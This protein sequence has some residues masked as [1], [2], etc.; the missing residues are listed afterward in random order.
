MNNITFFNNAGLP[1][2]KIS[3]LIKEEGIELKDWSPHLRQSKVKELYNV[4]YE[5]FTWEDKKEIVLCIYCLVHYVKGKSKTMIDT[6][7]IAPLFRKG[8]VINYNHRYNH[9]KN[10]ILENRSIAIGYTFERLNNLVT[11]YKPL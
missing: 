5:D 7:T 2:G 3:R 9:F 11:N 4:N 1:L 10:P 8:G 6:D